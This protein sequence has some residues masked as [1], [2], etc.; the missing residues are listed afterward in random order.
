M[1][2]E[3][4]RKSVNKVPPSLS[5]I[6]VN[7]NTT[8]LL[9]KCLAS[10]LSNEGEIAREII[11]VDNHSSDGGPAS[12][13]E[14][15]QDVKIIENQSNLGFSKACNQG[16]ALAIGDYI[17][18]LNPDT[19][20]PDRT[21][22]SCMAF[23]HEH[24]DIG[25]LGCRLLNGDGSLQPSCADFPYL[26]KI[27]LDHLLGWKCF[28]KT[29]RKKCLLKHW[30]HDRTRE[31]DWFLGAFMLARRSLMERLRGFDEDFFFYGEDL[32]LCYR[33]RQTGWKVVFFSEATVFHVGNSVWE[34][35]R[36]SLVY[37]ALLKFYRKHFSLWKYVVLKALVLLRRYS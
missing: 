26:H 12:L 33:I 1:R 4:S 10:V 18:F 14:R 24:Q 11:V 28:P 7:Y 3:A 25:A 5:I 13:K 6:I 30:A 36:I 16:L 35:A 8:V 27:F 2:T 20:V 22:D 19:T 34:N 29:M 15:F 32:D 21:L 31:V 23:I 9:K 37:D 17:L